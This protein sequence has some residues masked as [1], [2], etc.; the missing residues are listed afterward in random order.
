MRRKRSPVS[1]PPDLTTQERQVLQSI[2]DGHSI[3]QTADFL[4]VDLRAA[5]SARN[6]LK[7]KFRV[8]NTAQLLRE[9]LRYGMLKM[10]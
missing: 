2:W 9:A 3:A 10:K 1:Q 6:A 7:H 5:E 4:E 8:R